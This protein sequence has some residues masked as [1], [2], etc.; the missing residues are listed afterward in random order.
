MRM[1]RQAFLRAADLPTEKLELWVEY[2]WLI[3]EPTA[4]GPR[5]SE[6]DVARVRLIREMKD[7]FGANDEGVHIILHLLD[8]LYGVRRLLAEAR[9]ATQDTSNQDPR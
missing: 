7:D 9:A 1:T 4:S 3:P 2:E 8:Q 5:F 6:T